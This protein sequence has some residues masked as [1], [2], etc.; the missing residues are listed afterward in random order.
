MARLTDFHRQHLHIKPV[1]APIFCEICLAPGCDMNSRKPL[2][3]ILFVSIESG[4]CVVSLV[5]LTV[6]ELDNVWH[7]D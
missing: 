3:R 7:D 1:R 5:I 4:A 6:V 2:S